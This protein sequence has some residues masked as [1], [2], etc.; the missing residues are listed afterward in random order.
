MTVSSNTVTRA[1]FGLT[2]TVVG[3]IICFGA[4]GTPA[5]ARAGDQPPTV[6]VSYADLD[7][8][9]AA[10][11]RQLDRR[12]QSAAHQVCDTGVTGVRPISAEQNCRR[13]ALA[14]V[15]QPAVRQTAA[16]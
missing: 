14:N 7:L 6:R 4:A 9:S 8:G 15:R 2:G 16:R 13:L 10:G 1:V 12:L 5:Q 3:V 11:R